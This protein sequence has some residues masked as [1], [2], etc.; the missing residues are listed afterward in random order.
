MSVPITRRSL[1]HEKGEHAKT[2]AKRPIPRIQGQVSCLDTSDRKRVANPGCEL[3]DALELTDGRLDKSSAFIVFGKAGI[4]NTER[5]TY[6]LTTALRD[7]RLQIRRDESH[8]QR[9]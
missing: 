1:L 9:E 7:E 6:F 2:E 8:P 5:S 4:L 3:G